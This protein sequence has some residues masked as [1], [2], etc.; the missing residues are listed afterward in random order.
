M[1]AQQALQE[2][3]TNSQNINFFLGYP[4]KIKFLKTPNKGHSNLRSS[5]KPTSV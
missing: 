4:F 1:I 3:Y 5:L 2:K